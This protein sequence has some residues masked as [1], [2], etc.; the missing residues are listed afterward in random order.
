MTDLPRVACPR[1]GLPIVYIQ[2]QAGQR[3]ACDP[4]ALSV[5]V[6]GRRYRGLVD[7]EDMCRYVQRRRRAGA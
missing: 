7:H 2:S 5:W 6:D 3:M 1:C 4:I